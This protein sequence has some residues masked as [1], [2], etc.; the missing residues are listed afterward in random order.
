MEES[1]PQDG[2]SSGWR[3]RNREAGAQSLGR[4]GHAGGK[5]NVT[6]RM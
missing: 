6:A 5:G 3:G 4:E 1:S 2:G